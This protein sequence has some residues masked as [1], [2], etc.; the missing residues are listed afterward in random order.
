ML[1]L[2]IP[3]KSVTEGSFAR[4]PCKLSRSGVELDISLVNLGRLTAN[5]VPPVPTIQMKILPFANL[6]IEDTSVMKVE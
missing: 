5:N 6:V 4:M 2:Q 1:Q 3:A